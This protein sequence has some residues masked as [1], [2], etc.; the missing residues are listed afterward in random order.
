MYKIKVFTEKNDAD[1]EQQ[2]NNWLEEKGRAI[3]LC[4]TNL[5]TKNDALVYTICYKNLP[6]R[7]KRDSNDEREAA[8]A[9]LK[10]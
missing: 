5:S 2:I 3:E 7:I 9:I 4:T 1:I 6:T 10:S 8:R